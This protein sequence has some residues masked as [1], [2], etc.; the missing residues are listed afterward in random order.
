VVEALEERILH[1]ADLSPLGL[2]AGDAH[3]MAL[4]PSTQ[5]T[6]AQHSKVIFVDLAVPDADAVLANLQARRAAG[7]PIEVVT[8]AAHQDGIARISDTLAGRSGI[9]ALQLISHGSDGALQLGSARLDH[10]SLF[11]R[12]GELA[13]WGHALTPDAD[14]LLY[15]CDL[16]ASDTGRD[17]V[18]SLAALTGADVVAAAPRALIVV[19]ANLPD[20]AQLVAALTAS[21]LGEVEVLMLVSDR[22]ALAQIGE[23]LAQ[24]DQPFDAVH[25]ISHASPGRVDLGTSVGDRWLDEATLQA[26]REEMAGWSTGFT[27]D[28]DL[29]LYGCDLAGSAAGERLLAG[30]RAA[31]GVDVAAST[32][33]TGAAAQGGDWVLEY[34]LGEIAAGAQL[35][36]ANWTFTLDSVTANVFTDVVDGNTSSIAALIANPGADGGISLREAVSAANATGAADTITLLSGTYTLNSQLLVNRLLG[37]SGAGAGATFVDG[38]GS[39]RLFQIT[40]NSLL[41][42]K[43]TLQGGAATD[44]GALLVGAGVG[45][46]LEEVVLRDNAANFGGAVYSLGTLVATNVSFTNNTAGSSGGGLHLS[47][48]SAALTNATFSGNVASASGGAIHS[49]RPLSLTSSTVAHNVASGGVGGIFQSV[50]SNA[51]LSNTLL[52]NNTGGNANRALVSTGFNLDSDGSAGLTQGTDLSNVAAR[53]NPLGLAANGLYTHTLQNDSPV[54]D[55]GGG[56]FSATDAAGFVRNAIPDIGASENLAASQGKL[57]WADA[58]GDA[59]V[60]ANLD[61][62]AQQKIVIG[63]QTPRGV[64][65]DSTNGHVY[66]TDN[67]ADNVERANLDGSGRVVIKTGLSSPFGIDVDPAAGYIYVAEGGGGNPL[68]RMDLL[69]NGMTT[70]FT[71]PGGM[72][73]VAIAPGLGSL[74]V[75]VRGGSDRVISAN[76]DGSDPVVIASGAGQGVDEPSNVAVNSANGNV[77]WVNLDSGTAVMFDPVSSQ[78]TTVL[79]GLDRPNDIEVDAQAGLVYWSENGSGRIGRAN[80]DGSSVTTFSAN[81]TSLRDI[82]LYKFSAANSA[83]S[84]ADKTLTLLEDSGRILGAADFGFADTDGHAFNGVRVVNLPGAGSLTL[85][86]VAAVADQVVSAADIAAGKLVFTPAANANGIN[87]ASFQFRVRDDGGTANGGI[88]L[89]LTPNTLTFDVTPVNDAPTG[90]NAT[91]TILEDTPRTLIAAD[92]GFLDPLDGNA[93]NGVRVVSPPGA[94]SLGL[95]GTAVAASQDISAADIAAGRLV[96]TPALNANGNG[97]ASFTFQVRDNGG[98]ASGGVDRDP[99]P[100]TLTFDVTPVNDAPMGTSATL[101]ILEDT[102]RALMAADFGFSDIDGNA[103]GGI[104]IASLPLAGSLTFDGVA[105][106]AAQL[107]SAADIAAGKLVFTPAANASGNGYASFGFQVRDDGGTAG[108]GINLDPTPNTLTFDVTPVNDAPSG[109]DAT[110]TIL[111]DAPRTLTA[112]DFGFADSDGDGLDAV[113]IASLPGAG[114]LKLNGAA[115]NA[116]DFVSRSAI[117]AG[118]LVFTP[119]ANAS[120]N[121]YASFGFQVRDDGGTAGGG[122]N[123]DPTS[124]MLTF[125]VTPVNDAPAGTNAMLTIL[126]DTPRA[127][128]AADFGFMDPD[129]NAFSGVVIASLPLAGSLTFDGVAAVAAQLVSAADIAAGKLVFTPAAN[130]SGAGHASFGFQVRD[131]GG[132]AGGGINLDPTPNTLTFDVTPVNDA[133]VLAATL[134][135]RTVSTGETVRFQLPPASFSDQDAGDTL[136]Y[137]ATLP[138][139]SPLPAWL[140]FDG[141]TATFTGA[142]LAS[143]LGVTVVRVLATDASGAQ[144]QGVFAITV[145][146]PAAEEA[147]VPEPESEPPRAVVRASTAEPAEDGAGPVEADAPEALGAGSGDDVPGA[148]VAQAEQLAAALAGGALPDITVSVSS[149]SLRTAAETAVAGAA[150]RVAGG[151]ETL[152]AEFAGASTPG[153]SSTSLAQM[154]QLLASDELMRRFREVQ[155]QMQA[156]GDLERVFVGSSVV[157]G[158]GLS[159]GYVVWLLRGGILMSSMLSALPAWQLID[160]LPVLAAARSAKV[161][162]PLPGATEDPEVERLFD[163]NGRAP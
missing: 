42:E 5:F 8:I 14:V 147:V 138:D 33:A 160:P 117:D 45:V 47:G 69:G 49:E 61:G 57:Y 38:G 37:I 39:T 163:R 146:L 1:S 141:A 126:E 81:S 85:N 20:S 132:T 18:A 24:A 150:V 31:L 135:D 104:V 140:V 154:T 110:F 82:D 96:F 103:F 152:F 62:S 10:Q 34:Q 91:L 46:T 159:V 125:D 153:F 56:T 17:L 76:L 143:E 40:N 142:P 114:S 7:A 63:L 102:P 111:E 53:L 157:V 75:T 87:H 60:R 51:T 64:A 137:T 149:A 148:G 59:I 79:S 25:L 100:K 6:Q 101:T 54:V 92:F 106:V 95:N 36:A 2:S 16:A 105:A 156:Q 65:L 97:H 77:Y 122:I 71:A 162:R 12:A 108:G 99:T 83:P 116:G 120:G 73:G 74:L 52:A 115:V 44:G 109:A 119:A 124:N 22:D 129:G 144:A 107:V 30:L 15:G 27:A 145:A 89:D 130:A 58:S 112:A 98:T 48:G 113:R 41:L 21:S 72:S 66:W 19:A 128:A 29:L 139:G 50:G 88:D 9:A 151:A 158:S 133:P 4:L 127:L 67:A 90:T 26:R 32:D 11:A 13:Q 28:G 35:A 131:D 123:L 161:N 86:G 94:G 78:R 80:L 93:F 3:A 155:R 55:A 43:L 121:G 84:G 118:Q 23:R 136:T 70:L 134:P 68:R